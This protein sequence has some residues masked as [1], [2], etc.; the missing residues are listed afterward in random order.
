M[1]SLRPIERKGVWELRLGGR[2]GYSRYSFCPG[3]RLVRVVGVSVLGSGSTVMRRRSK[4]IEG[5]YRGE[6]VKVGEDELISILVVSFG[7]F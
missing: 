1:S 7:N 3:F 6:D 5:L 4:I 2:Q